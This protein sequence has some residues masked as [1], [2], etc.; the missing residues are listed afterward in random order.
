MAG[1]AAP[2]AL[3]Q[4]PVAV[5]LQELAAGLGPFELP[6]R[7]FMVAWSGVLALAYE[8]W[9]QEV[10]DF[11]RTLG[12]EL[13][14]KPENPGSVW[15]KTSLGALR[16][17][18][19]LT[20]E[21]LARLRTACARATEH[22]KVVG[23]A[24]GGA[25]QSPAVRVRVLHATT[26]MCR[27]HERLFCAVPLVLQGP[28]AGEASGSSREN[29]DRV[30]AAYEADDYWP[31]AGRDGSREPHYRDGVLGSSLVAFL[32]TAPA[33]LAELQREVEL[34]LPGYYAWFSEESLHCTV[35]GLI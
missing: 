15:P 11:K 13:A 28:P 19:R 20:P 23:S 31:D 5:R 6:P 34:A 27:S 33:G 2:A 8:G 21:D 9:P 16:S 32:G 12:R 17:G 25:G 14:L 24:A 10:E 29:T 1:T 18:R 7:C 26:F 4:P 22:L 30:I 35:R 3:E